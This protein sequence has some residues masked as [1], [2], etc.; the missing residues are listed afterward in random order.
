MYWSSADCCL[1]CRTKEMFQQISITSMVISESL[2][3]MLYSIM[4][5]SNLPSVK[6]ASWTNVLSMKA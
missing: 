1:S 5:L 2:Y 3:L 4:L 6:R